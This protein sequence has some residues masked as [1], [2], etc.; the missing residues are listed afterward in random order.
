MINAINTFQEAATP[1]GKGAPDSQ[2][3]GASYCYQNYGQYGNV[4]D[5]SCSQAGYYTNSRFNVCPGSGSNSFPGSGACKF[6]SLGNVERLRNRY[7]ANC[8]Q[9]PKMESMIQ[10]SG[11]LSGQNYFQQTHTY[12][13]NS[14][15]ESGLH[16][17]IPGWVS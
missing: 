11:V 10:V 4:T 12:L 7:E 15:P 3:C 14:L 13:G 16:S 1:S 8:L 2:V 6:Q 9:R 17:I 5:K